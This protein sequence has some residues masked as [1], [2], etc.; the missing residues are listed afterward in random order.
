MQRCKMEATL[1]PAYAPT[2]LKKN[3]PKCT[4]YIYWHLFK[5]DL[6][7]EIMKEEKKIDEEKKT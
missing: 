6:Q 3:E 7:C 4:S 1:A 5:P 2:K